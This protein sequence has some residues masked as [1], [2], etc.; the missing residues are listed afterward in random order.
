MECKE[1]FNTFEKIELLEKFVIKKDDRREPFKREK[2]LAGLTRACEKRPVSIKTLEAIA[3]SIEEHLHERGEAEIPSRQIG[4]AISDRL[5]EIDPVA[6]VRF[7]SVYR[8]FKDVG[9]FH[10]IVQELQKK[11][12]RG[13]R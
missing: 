2:I 6:Y 13:E 9:Q 1:R 8:Q 5:R 12:A 4:E 11:P 7:A 10:E 3:D